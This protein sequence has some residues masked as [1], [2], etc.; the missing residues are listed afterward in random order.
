MR[1]FIADKAVLQSEKRRVCSHILERLNIQPGKGSG[2]TAIGSALRVSRRFVRR[3]AVKG[4]ARKVIYL[5]H[6]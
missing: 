3:C 4:A 6:F 5:L 2:T 1:S